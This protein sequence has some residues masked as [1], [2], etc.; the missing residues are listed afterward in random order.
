MHTEV[1][2][3]I[4]LVARWS[5]GRGCPLI[6]PMHSSFVVSFFVQLGV[7]DMLK[8]GPSVMNIVIGQLPGTLERGHGVGGQETEAE[9]LI[10]RYLDS[11]ARSSRLFEILLQKLSSVASLQRGHKL[12]YYPYSPC[13]YVHSEETMPGLPH[14]LISTG[15]V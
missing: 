2:G 6:E 13:I 14:K 11:A 8:A 1:C 5:I 10:W 4:W 7:H 3:I 15:S 12:H 9:A